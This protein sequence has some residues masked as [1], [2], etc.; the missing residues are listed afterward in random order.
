MDQLVKLLRGALGG[1]RVIAD[2]EELLVYECDGVPHYKARPRAVVFPESTGEVSEVLRL[3]ARAGVP[4]APRGAGTGL[5]GGALAVGG[6]V[7]LSLAR[8]RRVLKVD[9]ENRLAVVEAGV[10][11]SQVSRAAA[12]LGLHYAPDPSSQATCTVGGNVA[13]NAGGIHCLK[14][15]TTVDHVL[16]LRVVLSDGR[17]VELGGAGAEAPGYD[18]VG[19]FVGSEGTFG[20]ATEATVRLTPVAP[21]VRTLLADFRDLGDASRAVSAVVAAGIIPAALEMVDGETIRAVEQ[22][23][24]AAGLPLDAEAALLVELDGFGAGLD[25]EV[26]RVRAICVGSGARGVR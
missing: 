16:G 24:F 7:Q 1:G 3:L 20:V 25:E 15:G 26:A 10:V 22:S 6:G 13:E 17:V 8:M 5:S 4:S 23:V 11:N 18:L 12:H 2:P 14:Y 9:A 19:V 21:S